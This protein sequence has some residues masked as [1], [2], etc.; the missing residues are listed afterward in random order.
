MENL[1][2][3]METTRVQTGTGSE[4]ETTGVPADTSDVTVMDSRSTTST[5][6]P[7]NNVTVNSTT[8]LNDSNGPL[9]SRTGEG[10]LVRQR[11]R[12]ATAPSNSNGVRN[13]PKVVT[14]DGDWDLNNI[15]K[16]KFRMLKYVTLLCLLRRKY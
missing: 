11:R 2:Y 7:N 12:R 4:R 8:D 6:N 13:K 9:D 1:A 16:A 10:W 5:S 15:Y 14:L 3:Y